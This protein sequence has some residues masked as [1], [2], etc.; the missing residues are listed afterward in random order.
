MG[1]LKKV[2]KATVLGIAVVLAVSMAGCSTGAAASK[3]GARGGRN[4]GTRQMTVAT[5]TVKMSDVGG[6]QIFTGSI[7]PAFTTNLSSKVSG[8]VAS[9]DVKVGD[10]VSVGQAIAKIDTTT[11]QQTLEQTKSSAAVSQAQYAKSVNDQA[12]SVAAAEKALAAQ[13][14]SYEKTISDQ[15][16]AV[17]AAKQAVATAQSQLNSAIAAQ[18]AS[19][20]SAKQSVASQQAQFNST[21]ASAQAAITVAQN[22]L[23]AQLDS[24]LSSENNNVQT[25]QVAVAAASSAYNVALQNGNAAGIDTAR[26]NLEKAQ[27]ALQQAQQAQTKDS[28]ST[29]QSLTSLQNALIQAQS[30]QGVQVAQENLNTALTALAN[31]QATASAQIDLSQQQLAQQQLTLANTQASQPLSVSS[32]KAA[33]DQ[34]Q[35][36]LDNAKSMDS[37][38]VS[39]A[40]LQQAQTNVKV[41]EEQL[42]DGVLTSPVEGVVTS[43]LTPVGQ[44]STQSAILSIASTDPALATVNVSEASIGQIKVGASMSVQVPTLKKT[45]Q[46]QVYSIH[47]AMDPT[48]KSYPVDIKVDDT[49]HELLPGMFAEASISSEGRQ[50]IMVPAS[51]VLNDNTGNSVYI[52]QNGKAKKVSVNIGEMTSTSFE[53]T[54]GL[55]VGDELVVQGQELLSDNVPV[56]TGQGGSGGGQGSQGGQGQSGQKGSRQGGG[57]GGG[58]YG[59]RQRAGQNGGQQSSSGQQSSD[60][61]GNAGNAKAGAGQ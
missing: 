21:D 50:A 19:V 42:Q 9:I 5:Q 11:L 59:Q 28:T 23:N 55:K 53:I 14:T 52:V 3:Q 39:A 24:L 46:G 33:L 51:A 56:S 2:K 6:G 61:G 36:S 34:A 18:Q 30:S 15:Q 7:S 41:V 13:Q 54:S 58:Q 27:L 1:K 49:N 8:R 40:Q 22:N 60:S 17:A 10:R 38:Q 20:A 45:F 4:G 43:I 32:A 35:Q 57:Q 37:V 47:P 29:Q 16:N 12:N 48:T 31:A 44:N 25:A 26:S